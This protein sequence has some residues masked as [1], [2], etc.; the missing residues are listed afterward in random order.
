MSSPTDDPAFSEEH[1]N[2]D[3]SLSS[4]PG[5]DSAIQGT[6]DAECSTDDDLPGLVD[7]A[8]FDKPKKPKKQERALWRHPLED[9]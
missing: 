6:T 5:I 7:V 9:E 2:V 3:H 8:L 4:A 1:A